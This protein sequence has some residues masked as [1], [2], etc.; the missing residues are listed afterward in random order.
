MMTGHKVHHYFQTKLKDEMDRCRM[1]K[2]Y[3]TLL[4][5][6]VD[7]FKKFNDTHG[8]QAGDQV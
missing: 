7:N 8:H 5:T 3:L 1:K 2:S 6:D 4:F